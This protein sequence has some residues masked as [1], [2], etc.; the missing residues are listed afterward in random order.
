VI[1]PTIFTL[2]IAAALVLGIAIGATAGPGT[3]LA[4]AAYKP[5]QLMGFYSP[6]MC[7][8]DGGSAGGAMEYCTLKDGYTIKF[9]DFS[10]DDCRTDGGRIKNTSW[11]KFCALHSGYA[12][13]IDMST[14]HTL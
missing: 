6:P 4:A 8:Q 11:G 2:S 14:S 1:K 5:A 3:A 9:G 13:K 7:T 10:D 12:V